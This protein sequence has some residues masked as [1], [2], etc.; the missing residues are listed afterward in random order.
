L[1][2]GDVADGTDVDTP[3]SARAMGIEVP[4]GPPP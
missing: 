3:E 4:T 2:C 1:P